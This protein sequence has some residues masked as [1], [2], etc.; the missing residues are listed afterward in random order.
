MHPVAAKE[1]VS[2]QMMHLPTGEWKKLE[3]SQDFNYRSLD[4]LFMLVK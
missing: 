2:N 1:L 3:K 4:Q